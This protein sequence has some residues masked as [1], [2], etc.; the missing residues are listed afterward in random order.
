MT[1]TGYT[2]GD[3]QKVDVAG[4]TVTGPLVL[5]GN[6]TAPLHAATKQYVDAASVSAQAYA[7]S[8]DAALLPLTGGAISGD[9]AVTG[10]VTSMGWPVPLLGRTGRLPKWRRASWSQQFQSG[11]G[12][13]ASASGV[14]SSNLND[15]TDFVRGTQS[16]RVTTNGTT[17]TP[18][19]LQVAGLPSVDLTGKDI[20]ILL[21]IDNHANVSSVNFFVGTSGF[22]N[23]FRWRL[24]STTNS[25][26]LLQSGDWVTVTL[27]WADVE[28][29]AGTFTLTGGVPSTKTG[30]TDFRVQVIDR[31][32]G[33]VTFRVQAVEVIDATKGTFP[34]GVV[35]VCFDDSYAS[36][37]DLARPIMDARG[38]PGTTYSIAE[39]VGT[40]TYVTV[41][42][43][44]N[45]QDMSGWEVAGHSY[46]AAA[47]T[48]RYPSLTAEEADDDLR[49]LKA[50]LVT[51]GFPSESFAYP[52]GRFDPTTDGV[53][54]DQ[55]VGRYFNSARSIL[56]NFSVET[57]PPAM[58]TRLRALSG[59]SSV[60]GVG[61]RANVTTLTGTGGGL[62]RCQA[63]GSWLILTFHRI[64][65]STPT[66]PAECSQADFQTV[67]DAIVARGIPTAT[68]ADV[69]NHY[70]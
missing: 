64:V 43:L 12:W 1:A 3:P 22:V 57:F 2:S 31:G 11:H 15:T 37:H 25:N 26:Q 29:A 28:S 46:S 9:L 17:A 68:V 50:W 32:A 21:K 40:P 65:T 7:D 66:D 41:P 59:I 23:F 63:Q 8:G 55:L 69:L 62:D 34:Q 47:H 42:Q 44:R 39:R 27:S 54:V 33:P 48:N 56:Y 70:A 14:A 60:I 58:R 49:S 45:V 10:R 67:M 19:N 6:P 4:D 5:P 16:A 38:I 24:H 13:V 18:A 20:R 51:N 35:T 30:F 36:V 61:D 52:G 53:P